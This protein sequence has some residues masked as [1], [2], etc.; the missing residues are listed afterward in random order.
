MKIKQEQGKRQEMIG[1]VAGVLSFIVVCLI[2]LSG[3]QDDQRTAPQP[4]SD[5]IS[6]QSEKVKDEE[7]QEFKRCL[8]SA[9]QG[10]V[11]SQFE[12]G[13]KY[14]QGD[15]VK[16]DQKQA[17][18]WFRKSAEQGDVNGQ[19][20][21]GVLY[22]KGKGVEQDHTQ[23]A[24]WY[25]K[26]VEQEDGDVQYYLGTMYSKGEGVK[27]DKKQGKNLI[28]KAARQG[29]ELATKTSKDWGELP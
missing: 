3:C 23:A 8:K 21:L 27:Q 24:K 15:G 11:D 1:S 4:E 10:D 9:E 20:I 28:R 7:S 29:H 13:V 12:L 22:Y 19:V 17:A 5:S 18:K 16:Q 2:V 25:G 6:I 26:A 14:H